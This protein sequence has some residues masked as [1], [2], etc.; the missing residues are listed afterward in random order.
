MCVCG[1]SVVGVCGCVVGEFVWVCVWWVFVFV[2]VVGVCG[3]CVYVCGGSVC[4]VCVGM[5][6]CVFG[7]CV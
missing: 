6:V 2:C 4:S 1:V 5:C 3:L 7:V